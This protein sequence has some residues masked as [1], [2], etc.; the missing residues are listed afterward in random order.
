[1]GTTTQDIDPSWLLVMNEWFHAFA[2]AGIA[3][4]ERG[5]EL[6][7]LHVQAT[8][9]IHGE[10]C[11]GALQ[12]LHLHFQHYFDCWTNYKRHCCIKI[13][14]E[15]V[16]H[17]FMPMVGYCLKDWRQPHFQYVVLNLPRTL[18]RAALQSYRRGLRK[19]HESRRVLY[20]KTYLEMVGPGTYIL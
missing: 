20:K 7:H 2:V 14:D 4:L 13:L 5:G 16:G 11:P 18:L 10:D 3:G 9:I 15:T 17:C 8:A 6:T 12:Q 1:M 19:S